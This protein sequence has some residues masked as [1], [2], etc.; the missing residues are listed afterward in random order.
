VKA[1]GY[2]GC[3]INVKQ[4]LST[5]VLKLQYIDESLPA[6]LVKSGKNQ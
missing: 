1:W 3:L 2:L 6:V 5:V 4:R